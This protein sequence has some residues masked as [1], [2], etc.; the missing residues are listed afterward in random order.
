MAAVENSVEWLRQKRAELLGRV[1]LM[2]A[3]KIT[4]TEQRGSTRVDITQET[5]AKFRRL[6]AEFDAQI[7][8][9]TSRAS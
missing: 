2:E 5:L 3:G 6:I 9:E 8:K 4:T 1:E 7:A